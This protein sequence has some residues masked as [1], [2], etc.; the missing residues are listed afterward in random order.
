MALKL[1]YKENDQFVEISSDSAFTN[2]LVSTHDGK[3]GDII[4]TQLFLRNDDSAKWYSNV[5]I[6]PYD[7]TSEVDK[8]DTDYESTGWGVKLS[9]GADEPTLAMWDDIDWGEQI[10]MSDVG[11]DIAADTSTYAPFWRL[12][13]CPP[14][15]DAQ[16]KLNIP[17]RVEYTENAV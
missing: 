13:S 5:T 1:Y 11:S 12:I 14:N 15:T 16:V 9:E 17:L 3:T 2:P 10:D 8:D 7:L 4:T 6:Q